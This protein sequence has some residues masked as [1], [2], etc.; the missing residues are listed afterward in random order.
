MS[1]CRFRFRTWN[2]IEIFTK[3][4]QL[5]KFSSISKFCFYFVHLNY[6]LKYVIEVDV[7]IWNNLA[8]VVPEMRTKTRSKTWLPLSIPFPN[9]FSNLVIVIEVFRIKIR[10]KTWLN[11][12]V[13]WNKPASSSLVLICFVVIIPM[14]ISIEMSK[15]NGWKRPRVVFLSSDYLTLVLVLFVLFLWFKLGRND[16]LAGKM[17]VSLYMGQYWTKKKK[18]LDGSFEL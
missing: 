3:H 2:E 8:T 6:N 17:R 13:I 7:K 12:R 14:T 9:T 1:R 5:S 10:L 11:K 16:Q 18:S 4:F 15:T